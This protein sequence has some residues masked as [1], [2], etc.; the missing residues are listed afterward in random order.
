ML[1]T[2]PDLE[3]NVPLVSP[4]GT[5]I[6]V[7][8]MTG[9]ALKLHL[10]QV[11]DG[12]FT[13][14]KMPEPIA[15]APV[16]DSFEYAAWTPDGKAIAGVAPSPHGPV[17]ATYSPASH[18]VEL[19]ERLR[20]KSVSGFTWLP[21]NRRFLYWDSL[22][23]TAVVSDLDASEFK[24]VAGIPPADEMKLS[25]DGRTLLLSRTIVDGDIWLLTL[26]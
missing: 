9:G 5:R 2:L 22:R 26:K 15:I 23:N 4:D 6:A 14:G 11:Q 8:G 18:R 12:W 20:G 19:H 16:E 24:D 7:G 25:A 10:A 1:T 3:L 13:P 21:D 17:P